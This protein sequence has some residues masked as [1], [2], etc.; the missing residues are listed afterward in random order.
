MNGSPLG[1][2]PDRFGPMLAE[3][4]RVRDTLATASHKKI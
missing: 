4:A 3:V 2:D 1:P